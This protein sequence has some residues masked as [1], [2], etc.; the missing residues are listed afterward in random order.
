MA[1]KKTPGAKDPVKKASAKKAKP[2]VFSEV[3]FV[4]FGFDL[5]KIRRYWKKIPTYRECPGLPSSLPNRH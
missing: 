1:P 3:K 4:Y 5:A 2:K